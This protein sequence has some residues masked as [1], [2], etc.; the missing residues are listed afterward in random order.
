MNKVFRS[1]LAL[2]CIALAVSCEKSALT[3]GD[4]SWVINSYEDLFNGEVMYS[5]NQEG[6]IDAFNDNGNLVLYVTLADFGW[7]DSLF[8]QTNYKI[9]SRTDN[10]LVLDLLYLEYDNIKKEACDYL[11]TFRGKRIY[12]VTSTDYDYYVYFKSNGKAVDVGKATLDGDSDYYY[13]DV[14]RVYCTRSF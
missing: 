13:Y 12:L 4:T 5:A 3:L 11:E 7:D 9:V 1:F 2:M 10:E 6:K 14:T 8:E